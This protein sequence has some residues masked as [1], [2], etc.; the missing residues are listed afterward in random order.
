MY[1]TPTTYYIVNAGGVVHSVTLE[2]FERVVRTPGIREATAEEIAAWYAA[3][4]LTPDGSPLVRT[5][6]QEEHT[7]GAEAA[8][9]SA[10]S[11]ASPATTNRKR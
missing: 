9:R 10:P 6:A 4:G 8:E 2:H 5:P 1:P 3:Q 11:P 7:E